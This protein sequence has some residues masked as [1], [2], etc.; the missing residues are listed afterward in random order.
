MRRLFAGLP[1]LGLLL[2]GASSAQA[3]CCYFSAKD[4]DILQPG[5]K[6]FISWNAEEKVEA[7]TVQPN[8]EGNADDFGMVIPTPSKP[9]LDEMPR[10]FFKE[11]AVYTILK[12]REQPQSK[13]LYAGFKG[14]QGSGRFR[15]LKQDAKGEGKDTRRST[16]VVLEAGGVRS[17][18]Y[19]GIKADR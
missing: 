14:G 9:K 12:K 7:F 10:D 5:Q 13:L 2:A 8:F 1:L 4:K 18:D 17:L 6:V 11:L 16:V 19:K 15:A 3:A